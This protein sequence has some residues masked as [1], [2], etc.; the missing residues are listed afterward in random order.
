M[1]SPA[2]KNVN[3]KDK[4]KSGKNVSAVNL[5]ALAGLTDYEIFHD[6]AKISVHG[7]VFIKDLLGATGSEI[8]INKMPSGGKVPFSHAHKANEEIFIFIKGKGE[9][10]IDDEIFPVEEGSC[11]RLAPDARRCLRNNGQEDLY[12]IVVQTKADSLGDYTVDDG[13]KVEQN[14]DW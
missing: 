1:A 13:Y 11:L 8:S 10:A 14:I 2:V 7:K 6:K 12:F 4:V 5:G 3:I 9:M